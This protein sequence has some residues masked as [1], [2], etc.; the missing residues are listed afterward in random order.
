MSMP[1][2]NHYLEKSLHLGRQLAGDGLE[3]VRH[4][5]VERF[6][7]KGF[8]GLREESWKYTDVRSIAG[9]NF[10]VPH[11]IGDRIDRDTVNNARLSGVDC[12]ELVFI[13]GRFAG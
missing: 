4:T 7:E 2:I 8:P 5:G 12:H 1:A 3:S 10:S 11:D 9:G 6:R 13:N